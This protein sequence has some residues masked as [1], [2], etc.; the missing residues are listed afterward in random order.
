M[1]LP[2]IR[3]RIDALDAQLLRLLNQRADLVHEVGLVK[4][5]EGW[6]IYAP[7]REELVLRKLAAMNA[8]LGGRLPEGAVRA[9]YR[10]IMS[11]SLALE[12]H[13]VIA[14]LGPEATCAHEAARSKFGASVEYSAQPNVAE[15]FD[16]VER[17]YADYGV[18]P[19]ENSEG[20]V[21]LTLEVFTESALRVCAQVISRAEK[22]LLATGP[23]ARIR[24]LYSHPHAFARH[25]D[26]IRR[27]LPEAELM[28]VSSTRRAAFLAASEADAAALA[29]RMAAETCGLQILEPAIPNRAD[30]LT[31]FLVIGPRPSPPTGDD[32]TMILFGVNHA[33][34]ALREALEPLSRLQLPGKIESRPSRRTGQEVLF[35]VEVEGHAD[36]PPLLEAMRQ[37]EPHCTF[38][39]VLG[40]YP[41]STEH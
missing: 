10:E 11:A 13:L 6:E 15:V 26:W 14:Y 17:G 41:N 33:P 32:K 27:N 30:D 19:L 12:K 18:V 7:E 22:F 25:A 35:C 37:I 34:G 23:R 40:T 36:D 31:R 38:V 9:I 16:A 1:S 39:K 8:E 2:A 3:Q 20:A 29:S 4:K 24:R 5:A 28:E 21:S